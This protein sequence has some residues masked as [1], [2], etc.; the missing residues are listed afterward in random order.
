VEYISNQCVLKNL[1]N[2][3]VAEQ[4]CHSL[5]TQR[6]PRDRIHQLSV[7]L[8]QYN[9]LHNDIEFFQHTIAHTSNTLKKDVTVARLDIAVCK[10]KDVL[11]RLRELS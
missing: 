7:L 1:P 11:T 4:L 6:H 2:K 9:K 10:L 3:S 5:N 8:E